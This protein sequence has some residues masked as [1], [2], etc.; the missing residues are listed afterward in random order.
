MKSKSDNNNDV[1]FLKQTLRLAKKGLSW[2]NP[3]P[4]VG[5]LIVKEGHVIGKGFHHKIGFP[6]AEIEALK[7]CQQIP[8]GSTL[9]VNLEPCVH[10]GKTPPCAD[11]II[12]SGIKRVVCATEDPNPKVSGKGL[13]VL[14]KAGI[15]TS[16]GL[17]GAEAQKLNETFFTFHKKKRP[18]VAIKFAA[19]LDGKMATSGG[20]SKWITNEKAR[21]YARTLR[22][23]YQAIVVGI[24][25]VLTDNPHLG[26]RTKDRKDPIRIVLDP[27]L[28]IPGN[29]AALR[30]T[31]VIIITSQKADKSKKVNL[32]SQGITVISTDDP[33]SIPRL[34]SILKD[35]EIISVLVEGGGETLGRFI[36]SGMVDKVYAFHAP[37]LI[38]GK[39]AKSIGGKG[40]QT[41]QK[42]IRLTD[43]SYKIFGDNILT[44]GYSS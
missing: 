7:N 3:N 18:F 24:N 13:A 30:D 2:T 25:T 6:H 31:N 4:M 35:K 5:A 44:I 14:Q 39:E 11:A 26:A 33:V 16:V 28:Q 23:K 20:D 17:L 12:K 1:K 43:I 38:G 9:Y 42:A 15:K 34:L 32:E 41:I 19:S 22:T 8:K 40:A 10:F 27:K 21:K 36:D 37:I 29:A